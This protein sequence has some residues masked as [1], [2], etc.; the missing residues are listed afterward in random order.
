MP[1]E[2]LS[3]VPPQHS[4]GHGSTH[5][6][7]GTRPRFSWDQR[8]PQTLP[9]PGLLGG[10]GGC[11]LSSVSEFLG[12]EE[13]PRTFSGGLQGPPTLFL[14]NLKTSGPRAFR[15]LATGP[16]PGPNLAGAQ[17]RSPEPPPRSGSRCALTC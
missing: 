11:R 3:P 9:G 5:D 14:E 7:P 15:S 16:K 8:K 13:P 17:P 12:Q 1:P 4:H 10:S 2:S 6:R